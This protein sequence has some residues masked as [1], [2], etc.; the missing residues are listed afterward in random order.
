[1]TLDEALLSGLVKHASLSSGSLSYVKSNGTTVSAS[2]FK[3]YQRDNNADMQDAGYL[4]GLDN[5]Y[6]LAKTND[7]SSWGLQPLT[8]T[9]TL[10]SEQFLIG[11][12]IGKTNAYWQIYLR[13]I[14]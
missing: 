6:V 3:S 4:D 8:S 12:T 11:R 5:L 9:V 1:M 7:V 14:I 13:K 2:V 10:D